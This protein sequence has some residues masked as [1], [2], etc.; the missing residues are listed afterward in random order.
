MGLSRVTQ[1]HWVCWAQGRKPAFNELAL[2]PR[3]MAALQDP[4]QRA[5]LSTHQCILSAHEKK[6]AEITGPVEC[7]QCLAFQQCHG[8]LLL[9]VER[10]DINSMSKYTWIYISYC[11][12][13]KLYAHT[14]SV[15][16]NKCSFSRFPLKSLNHSE[17]WN[18]DIYCSWHSLHYCKEKDW[19]KN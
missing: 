2:R 3:Y 1:V 5:A 11:I 13:I 19:T 6:M 16:D 18:W 12:I 17:C 7:Q 10:D 4:S 8:N 9:P 14:H 15:F